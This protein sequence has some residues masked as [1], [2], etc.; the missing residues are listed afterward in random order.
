MGKASVAMLSKGQL[1]G[2]VARSSARSI[3]TIALEYVLIVLGVALGKYVAFPWG[4]GAAVLLIGTRQYA[5]GECMAH[6]A[7]H[8]NLS[9]KTWLNEAL[10]IAVS[11]PFFF[12]LQG[13]R[14]FHNQLH[15][16]IDLRDDKN[17]IFEDY[18]SWGLPQNEAPLGRFAACWHLIGKPLFGI[19]GFRHLVTTIQD[20]Y[21]D[22]DLV[23]NAMMLGFWLLIALF[24]VHFDL[25]VD[26]LL[27]WIVPFFLVVPILNYWSEV[28]D[29]YRVTGAATRSNLNWCLNAL[30]AHNIGYH[31][32]H[33]HRPAIPWFQLRR[34]YPFFRS[35]LQE[36]VSTGYWVT[37]RQIMAEERRLRCK[38]PGRTVSRWTV[39]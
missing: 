21:W 1:D 23:E 24:A 34:A 25:Q 13:Y 3:A 35:E 5:L 17:S 11:W 31:G 12:T 29:H 36:Q 2:M 32:L 6:E 16:R 39:P 37:F 28:G 14:R 33:H 7:S 27:Y 15:H 38:E 18:D 4:Y 10:G 20:F 19:I 26:M 9:R 30:V 8:R 22:S